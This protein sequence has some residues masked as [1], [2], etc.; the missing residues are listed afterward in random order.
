MVVVGTGVI[1]IEYASM[2]AALGTKVT[3]IEKTPTMLDF[4]D[5]EIIES[6]KFHLR[7]LAVT[8][9]VRRRGDRGGRGPRRDL[10]TLASG[11]Q[12]PAETV[13][14]SA[15]PAGT[16]Q[17]RRRPG[18]DLEID[19]RGRIFVDDNYQTKVDHIYA[20]GDVIGFPALAATSMDQGPAGLSRLRRAL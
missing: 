20:V 16:D 1:G 11:K 2:F 7:D 4:C 5:S 10:T 17:P 13:M 15:G 6:L 14:Y 3:V 18:R 9:P 8:F 19:S 12:I